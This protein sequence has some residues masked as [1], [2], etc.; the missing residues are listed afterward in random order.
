[1]PK[2]RAKTRAKP[3]RT[4]KRSAKPKRKAPPAHKAKPAPRAKRGQGTIFESAGHSDDYSTE[5]Y[6]SER[7]EFLEPTEHR[8][9]PEE[10]E[11]KMH[12]GERTYD[13]YTE[14]GREELAEEDGMAPWE[15][16]FAQ[17][18]A[19]RGSGGVCAH[20]GKPLAVLQDAEPVLEQ[21]Y[22]ERILFFCSPA[23][24]RKH[25]RKRQE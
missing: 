16:G 23:C 19:G 9:T 10:L 21:A 15:Q 11:L 5:R 3:K 6:D 7:D 13:A 20:C 18:A 24:A 14:E 17:G 8:E 1:M 12:V 4:A 22:G 25:S 2:K